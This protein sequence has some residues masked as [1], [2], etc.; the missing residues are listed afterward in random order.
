MFKALYSYAHLT[1]NKIKLYHHYHHHL[2]SSPS[3]SRGLL[4][5]LLFHSPTAELNHQQRNIS[6]LSLSFGGN[7]D[8]WNSIEKL[9]GVFL[10]NY[11][12]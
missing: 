10:A 5:A 9:W 7:S 11:W 8:I 4:A 3:G 6:L 2:L 1:L 12:L